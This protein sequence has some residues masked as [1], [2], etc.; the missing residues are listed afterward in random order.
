[1][2]TGAG[3]VVNFMDYLRHKSP[4]IVKGVGL[5]AVFSRQG[6]WAFDY[7]LF[8]ARHHRTRL[9][10]FHF[11]ESP[12]KLRRDVVFI[13]AEKTETG[14]VTPELIARKDQE[15]RHAFEERL[16]DYEEVGFRVCEG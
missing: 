4:G 11:L 15:L 3:N 1:M 12:Y 8:L 16:G 5:C 14:Q 9:N 6:D 2:Q 13:D 7:A 10:I